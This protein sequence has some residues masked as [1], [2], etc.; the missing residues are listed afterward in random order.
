MNLRA[1][2]FALAGL[3][4]V[5]AITSY[6]VMRDIQ[7][8]QR[9]STQ[10][11]PTAGVMQATT[12]TNALTADAPASNG[13]TSSAT[14]STAT[15]PS[16]T[17]TSDIDASQYSNDPTMT[18]EIPRGTTESTNQSGV[19]SPSTNELSQRPVIAQ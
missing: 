11:T 17:D 1:I 9:T 19:A 15:V 18:Q 10:T 5:S 8:T 12:S 14:G 13:A 4:A 2:T 6:F 16:A 3:I 7:N